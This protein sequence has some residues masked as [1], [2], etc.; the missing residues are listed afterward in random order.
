MRMSQIYNI[1]LLQ[2]IASAKEITYA[3]LRFRY[4]PPKQPGII[5][6]VEVSFDRDLAVLEEEGFIS[7]DGDII[8]YIER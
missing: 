5:Q 7:R 3:E 6:G 2:V 4:L 8:H 1:S